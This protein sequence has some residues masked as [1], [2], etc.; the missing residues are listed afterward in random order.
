METRDTLN[1]NVTSGFKK[2]DGEKPSLLKAWKFKEALIEA[3]EVVE[4]GAEKYGDDNWRLCE[5]PQRYL[6]AVQRHLASHS[7]GEI[8]DDESGKRHLAHALCSLM[9]YM[10]LTHGDT[11]IKP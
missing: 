4:F 7:Q 1:G 11:N 6:E 8:L 9:M 5:E 10:E 3:I 2:W